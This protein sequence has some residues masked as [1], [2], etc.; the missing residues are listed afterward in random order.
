MPVPLR[1]HVLRIELQHLSVF[2]A[3]TA[4]NIIPVS[5]YLPNTFNRASHRSPMH[6]DLG[7]Q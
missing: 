7:E 2:L 1:A 6:D 5:P 3:L 4:S